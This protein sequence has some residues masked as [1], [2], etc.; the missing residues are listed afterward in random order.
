MKIVQQTWHA[1]S[2]QEVMTALNSDPSGL[3]ADEAAGTGG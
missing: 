2:P 1:L 3:A